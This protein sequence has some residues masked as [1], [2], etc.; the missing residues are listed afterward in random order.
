MKKTLLIALCLVYLTACSSQ[1]ENTPTSPDTTPIESQTNSGNTY[2]FD[3]L[4]VVNKGLVEEDL[5]IIN[6]DPICQLFKENAYK[7]DFK[8]TNNFDKEIN[9]TGKALT[10]IWTTS[11][12]I[13]TKM[14]ELGFEGIMEE[15][16]SEV[17]VIM[18]TEI[19]DLIC[20]VQQKNRLNLQP[21]ETQNYP[22]YFSIPPNLRYEKD[23]VTLVLGPNMHDYSD[24]RNTIDFS[25]E[26]IELIQFEI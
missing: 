2:N 14:S 20:F 13:T 5:E 10:D 1:S 12:I 9:F 11:S 16:N 7:V 26:N 8:L 19:N 17:G 24:P 6:S 3:S 4:V 22:L 15:A 18:N 23:T 25:S 21:G